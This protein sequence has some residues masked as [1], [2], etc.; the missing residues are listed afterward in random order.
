MYNAYQ[1]LAGASRRVLVFMTETFYDDYN[2]L[3][4][5]EMHIQSLAESLL[6]MRGGLS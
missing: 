4:R 2:L 3:G 6:T 5:D 1:L